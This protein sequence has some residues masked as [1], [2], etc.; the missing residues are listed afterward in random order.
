MPLD[1]VLRKRIC[2]S[3]YRRQSLVNRFRKSLGYSTAHLLKG[4]GVTYE[5]VGSVPVTFGDV[6]SKEPT[7]EEGG[8]QEDDDS[9]FDSYAEAVTAVETILSLEK[10][11]QEDLILELVAR[12]ETAVAGSGGASLAAGSTAELWKTLSIPNFGGGA[13]RLG[14]ASSTMSLNLR[15]LRNG[16]MTGSLSNL[17][18]Q[19][20]RRPAVGGGSRRSLAPSLLR[21]APS[22]EENR[23]RRSLPASGRLAV[24]SSVSGL[25]KSMMTLTE[26]DG[27][28]GGAENKN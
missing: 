14:A 28:G 23:K 17:A 16:T 13:L 6:S 12:Q 20:S 27:G 18:L 5:L 24:G 11:R 22:G 2:F 1:L 21:A 3:V 7:E 9:F 19:D 15:P 25:K 26:E 10:L 4:L 8:I